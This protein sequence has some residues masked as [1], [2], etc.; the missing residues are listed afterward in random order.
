[1]AEELKP[2]TAEEMARLERNAA[3]VT[4]RA[5]LQ[6]VGP[7]EAECLAALP[8]AIEQIRHLQEYNEALIRDRDHYKRAWE[9]QRELRRRCDQAVSAHRATISRLKGELRK[10]GGDRG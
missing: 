1:M 4:T 7:L 3:M 9:E 6:S 10:T 8:R 2:L 5:R